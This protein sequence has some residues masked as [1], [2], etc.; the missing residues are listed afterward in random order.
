[1]VGSAA[2]PET[3]GTGLIDTVLMRRL[4]GV[5][6][7]R[8]IY[9]KHGNDPG[10]QGALEPST[11]AALAARSQRTGSCSVTNVDTEAPRFPLFTWRRDR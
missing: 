8:P 4:R 5:D 6:V 2:D 11:L 7:E 10:R 3:G 1:M 9:P